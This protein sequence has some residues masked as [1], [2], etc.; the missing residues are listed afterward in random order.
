MPDAIQTL[1]TELQ[2]F[3]VSKNPQPVKATMAN[4]IAA[5]QEIE[6]GLSPIITV[7]NA[8]TIYAGPISGPAALPTFRALVSADIPGGSGTSAT[9]LTLAPG[10]AAAPSLVS[11]TDQTGLYFTANQLNLATGGNLRWSIL[12][13][14]VFQNPNGSSA[15]L[16]D[17]NAS[18]TVP[19]LVPN[20]NSTT[21]GWGAQ[22]SGNM[23]GIVAGAEIERITAAGVALTATL[24]YAWLNR[25]QILSP[26]DGTLVLENNAGTGFTELA[27]GGITAAFPAWARNSTALLAQLADGSAQAPIQAASIQFGAGAVLNDYE[28]GTW[29]PADNSGATLAFASVSTAYTKIGNMV[30]AYGRL[31]FPVTGSVANALIGGLPFTS[32]NQPY[33]INI[34]DLAT[35]ASIGA[36]IQGVVNQNNTQFGAQNQLTAA[37]ITNAQLSGSLIV[38]SFAYPVT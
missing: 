20:R 14:G 5:F 33:A 2:E 11:S 38:F 18:S 21:T 8:N 35:N 22:A 4:L 26:S 3:V 28:V 16:I 1:I 10:S 34:T 19:T 23:S 13:N 6:A 25:S 9:Q 24:S 7:E 36:P 32:A 37:S 29:T 15:A 27:F 30:Y 12:S 31:T 17:L